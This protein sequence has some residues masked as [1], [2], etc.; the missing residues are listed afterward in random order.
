M[1]A[2][3]QL[4]VKRKFDIVFVIAKEPLPFT[5][6][7]PLCELQERRGVDLGQGYKLVEY[8]ALE[9]RQALVE[10]LS[11]AKFYSVQADGSTDCE[12][13]EDELLVAYFD[14][15]GADRKVYTRKSS[16]LYDDW[17]VKVCLSVLRK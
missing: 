13:I 14:P 7:K 8:I 12:N 2:G 5:K 15:H 11:L 4:M 9:P 3:T 16:L 1:D 6:M 10:A 17:T